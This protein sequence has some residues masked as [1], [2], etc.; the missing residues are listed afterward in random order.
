VARGA[1]G[2]RRDCPA[3]LIAVESRIE[4]VSPGALGVTHTGYSRRWRVLEETT[5]SL[6]AAVTVAGGGEQGPWWSYL[7]AWP[8]LTPGDLGDFFGQA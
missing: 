5:W 7:Q 6:S 8:R 1:E 3:S 2:H 4:D